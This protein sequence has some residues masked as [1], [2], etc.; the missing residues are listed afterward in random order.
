MADNGQQGGSQAKKAKIGD[1]N[2]SNSDE[3][4][5]RSRTSP[6]LLIIR[7][8]QLLLMIFVHL[9]KSRSNGRRK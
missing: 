7:P 1:D 9:S 4:M 5:P 6:T 8:M 3:R 2:M